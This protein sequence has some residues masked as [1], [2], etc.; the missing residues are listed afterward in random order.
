[1]E[2]YRTDK[3]GNP[4]VFAA[5][6]IAVMSHYPAHV[7]REVVSP[8]DGLPVRMVFLP[9]IAEVKT[10]CE[11]VC[12]RLAMEDRA[13]QPAKPDRAAET[14]PE[15]QAMMQKRWAELRETLARNAAPPPDGAPA[16]P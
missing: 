1:M 16:A 12:I 3:V 5:G 13:A 8:T 6:L 7:L 2:F 9:S 11:S 14:T 15:H 10:A 4:E